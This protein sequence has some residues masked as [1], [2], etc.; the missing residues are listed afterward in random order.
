MARLASHTV[1]AYD[2]LVK[3]VSGQPDVHDAAYSWAP[4]DGQM[5]FAM[6]QTS[7]HRLWDGFDVVVADTSGGFS[8]GTPLRGH[9]VSMHVGKPI[10]ADC[11]CDGMFQHRLQVP[12]D[13]DV[14]PVGF[15]ATWLD[16]GPTR[17]ISVHITA[18]LVQ[19]AA[20]GMGLDVDRVSLV[21]QLQL[22][23]P[24][25]QHVLWALQGE[26]ESE[27]NLGRFYGESLGLALTAHLLRRYAPIAP[28]PLG[29]G[30]GKRRL[31]RVVDYVHDHLDHD[32]SLRE[33]A[34]IANLSSSHFKLLFKQATGM[35]AHQFVI[36]CRVERAAELLL[37]GDR[38]PSEVALLVGFANQSHMAR[39]MRRVM[40]VSPST[41]MRNVPALSPASS[42]R[43]TPQ[44]LGTER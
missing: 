18:P 12:G 8:E 38:R 31:K 29:T 28:R 35:P 26:L 4:S 40:G 1:V 41:L 16:G 5:Q 24:Q 19:T 21:P 22:R 15:S 9:S 39:S 25:I 37:G 3:C 30:L 20:E 32:L 13:I 23:D 11:R 27:E 44:S 6:R 2:E 36:K 7:L 17:V 33:L 14:V 34:D 42:D 10:V 43:A